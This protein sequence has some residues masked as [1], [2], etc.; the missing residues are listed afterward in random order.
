M[1][2]RA[3]EQQFYG[4]FRVNFSQGSIATGRQTVKQPKV[5]IDGRTDKQTR[6]Y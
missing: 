5:D 4:K 6:R 1:Q 3:L 2:L